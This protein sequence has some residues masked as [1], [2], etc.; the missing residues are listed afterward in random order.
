MGDVSQQPFSSL[1]AGPSP[2][3]G[4]VKKGPALGLRP[5]RGGLLFGHGLKVVGGR[6]TSSLVKT[7]QL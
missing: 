5:G 6:F 7:S 1:E 4:V 2:P 3:R